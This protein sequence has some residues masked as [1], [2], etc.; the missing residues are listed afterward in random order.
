MFS[1]KLKEVIQMSG[2]RVPKEMQPVYDSVAEWIGRA[3]ADAL[4]DEY[5]K[6]A[7]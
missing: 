4:N 3:C 5:R 6:G 7:L 2:N 1:G